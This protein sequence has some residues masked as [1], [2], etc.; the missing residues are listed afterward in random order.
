MIE[1]EKNKKTDST[2]IFRK[3]P[4]DKIHKMQSILAYFLEK[5]RHLSDG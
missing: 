2:M 1:T 5:A 4:P 3:I